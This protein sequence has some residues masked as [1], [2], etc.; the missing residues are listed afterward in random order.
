MQESINK[1]YS[2]MPINQGQALTLRQVK[3]PSVEVVD[4]VMA[5]YMT[6]GMVGRGTS[7]SFFPQNRGGFQGGRGR[8]RGRGRGG[9]GN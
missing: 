3:E 2:Q 4:G 9:N 1:G 5:L 7:K 8:G 6:P